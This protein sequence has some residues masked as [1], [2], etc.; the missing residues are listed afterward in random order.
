MDYYDFIV[1][2]Y[3]ALALGLLIGL[4]REFRQHPAGLRT[5]ALVCVGSAL[6]MS[7]TFLLQKEG[8]GTADP[9]R[10]ASYIISGI[11][12]LGGG[13]ILKQGVNIRGMN[14]AATL[15]CS[16]AIGALCGAGH[17]GFALSG[18]FTVLLVHLI[19]RPI[20]NWVLHLERFS[21]EELRFK[22]N[23]VITFG[24]DTAIRELF[25]NFFESNPVISLMS[26]TTAKQEALKETEIT[27]QIVSPV[28][29]QKAILHLVD[30]LNDGPGVRVVSWDK[31]PR[32]ND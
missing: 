22:I 11:G 29:K 15:W 21:E 19:F 24:K 13:V 5:N 8:G 30:I 27:A 14:T 20:S 9:T 4:E 25:V 1:N 23:V 12:F 7:L 32:I 2:V 31:E 17:W 10:I 28:N 26:L 6:F 16:A 18:A 3:S